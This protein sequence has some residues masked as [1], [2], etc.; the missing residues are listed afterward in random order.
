MKDL[1]A[2]VADSSMAQALEAALQRP[3]SLGIRPVTFNIIIHP[4]RDCGMRINGPQMLALQYQ[5]Y[6]YGLLMLDF[7]GSGSQHPDSITLENELDKHLNLHWQSNA[8]AI[9]INPELDIW[10]WGSDNILKQILGWSSET[11]LRNWLQTKGIQFLP[12]G[13][14]ERPKEAIEKIMFEMK[15]P[16]SSALYYKIASRVS[17]RRCTDN[18]FLRLRD[19]LVNWFPP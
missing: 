18:S 14:P 2:L 12:N 3:N 15:Q 8:K 11:S 13:K 7:E 4:Q 19:T 16:R 6:S 1:A 9:V 5:Q 17:L 10:M